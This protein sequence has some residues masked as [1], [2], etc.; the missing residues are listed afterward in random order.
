[1]SDASLD[2]SEE[3]LTP[4]RAA[5][6]V[7]ELAARELRWKTLDIRGEIPLGSGEL[8]GV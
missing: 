2:V 7:G 6:S 8:E 4:P 3:A 1:M 5:E